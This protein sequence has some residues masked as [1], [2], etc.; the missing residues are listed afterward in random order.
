[1]EE[2]RNDVVPQNV[3]NVEQSTEVTP[4]AVQS[5][6]IDEDEPLL[7]KVDFFLVGLQLMP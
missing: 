4:Q 3:E 2:V 5:T 6:P 1:M 7:K